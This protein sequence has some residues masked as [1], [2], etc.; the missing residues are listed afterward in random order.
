[1]PRSNDP[2]PPAK[3]A[4]FDPVSGLTFEIEPYTGPIGPP[5][6]VWTSA[7][8]NRLFG[9]TINENGEAI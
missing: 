7:V 1:M 3:E 4:V 5:I 8:P 9:T 6:T 2:E